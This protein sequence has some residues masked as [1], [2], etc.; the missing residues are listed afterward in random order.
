MWS[1][2][3]V[4]PRHQPCMYTRRMPT[5]SAPFVPCRDCVCS[6]LRRASRA[7]TQ[8]FEAQFRGS[9]IRGTQFTI[10]AMLIQTEPMAISHLATQLGVQRT[11]LTRNLRPLD[12]RKLVSLSDGRARLVSITPEGEALALKTLPRWRKAQASVGQILAQFDLPIRLHEAL[13]VAKPMAD[14]PARQAPAKS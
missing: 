11:T 13:S 7:V 1:E 10:L 12:R 6:A 9:G 3:A 2:S 5:R 4:A 14:K 8:H